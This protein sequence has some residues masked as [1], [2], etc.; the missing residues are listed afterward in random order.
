LAEPF[1]FVVANVD[2]C[3]NYIRVVAEKE[4]RIAMREDGDCR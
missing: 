3:C 1:I 2:N 4:Q